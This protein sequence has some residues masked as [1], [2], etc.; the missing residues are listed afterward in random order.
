MNLP[1]THVGEQVIHWFDP[2]LLEQILDD[3]DAR[4]DLYIDMSIIL[5][6]VPSVV[7]YHIAIVQ[8]D[9]VNQKSYDPAAA[10]HR[11]MRI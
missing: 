8:V 11:I 10:Q 4:A 5:A 6:G 2:S 1:S 9:D 3:A 7:R